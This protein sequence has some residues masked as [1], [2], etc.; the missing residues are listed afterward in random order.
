MVHDT[1]VKRRVLYRRRSSAPLRLYFTPVF[2]KSEQAVV[3]H[4][5]QVTDYH[6]SILAWLVLGMGGLVVLFGG[7]FKVPWALSRHFR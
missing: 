3:K 1:S 2:W 6:Q 7:L 5:T 4:R